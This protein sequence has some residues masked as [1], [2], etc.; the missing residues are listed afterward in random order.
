MKIAQYKNL[1]LDSIVY[2]LSGMILKLISFI[3]F[4]IFA[5]HFSP[6]SYGVISVVNALN[7]L[8]ITISGLG[9]EAASARWF[10]DQPGVEYRK[11]VFSTW[12]TGRL[13]ISIVLSLIL[14]FILKN[15]LVSRHLKIEQGDL[16]LVVISGNLLFNII[17][18]ILNHYFIL[19]KKPLHSLILT[20]FLALL[21]SGLCLLFVFSF[22][23]DVVGFFLGQLVAFFIITLIGII[24]FG[25]SLGIFLF[26]RSLLREM[27]SYG[28]KVIPATL[29]NNFSFFF[30]TL[31]I[32]SVTSQHDLG[33]FQVGFTLATGIT[34]LT[35][36]FSQAMIPHAL[37]LNNN[38][39]KRFCVW[40]LDA[41]CGILLF[42]CLSLGVFYSDIISWLLSNKYIES[43]NVAGLLTFS[44]FIISLNTI[45]SMG[46]AKVKRIEMFGIAILLSNLIL[47]FVLYFMTKK[48]GLLG[49][50]LS[51]L[52]INLSSVTLI[53]Y[54]GHKIMPIGYHYLKNLMLVLAFIV[55]YQLFAKNQILDSPSLLTKLLIM[56]SGSFVLLISNTRS[57]KKL[58]L[59]FN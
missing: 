37:S 12:F 7:L 31:I 38:E 50:S 27:T 46:M 45:G 58:I 8:L 55:V 2:G 49:S 52:I 18:T 20:V 56:L 28:L 42:L 54:L 24:Y 19:N 22:H 39:F 21:S 43:A 23:L 36:G 33:I 5:H 30:A 4:P 34:F 51:F 25:N 11:K 47:L 17:P 14:F 13:I 32:Q 9:L 41:Y 59:H 26:E 57:I 16:L 35:G 48:Y 29:S 53:F 44:H 6:E 15:W 10:Y 40:S 1:A 3:L